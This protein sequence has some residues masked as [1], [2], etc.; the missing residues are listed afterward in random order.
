[1]PGDTVPRDPKRP[2][3]VVGPYEIQSEIAHGAMGVVYRARD[4]TAAG[5]AL[6]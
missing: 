2:A 5:T 6:Y 4:T 3:V 1:M